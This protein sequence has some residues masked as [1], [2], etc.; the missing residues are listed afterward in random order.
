MVKFED[1]ISLSQRSFNIWKNVPAPKRAGYLREIA[2]CFKDK[3]EELAKTI[4]LDMGKT[5]SESRGEVQEAID[6]FEYA[7]GLSRN[8]SGINVPSERSNHR[9]FEQWHPLGPIGIITAFNFPLAVWAWNAAIATVCGN[10]VIWKPSE[11]TPK[12]SLMTQNLIDD[13]MPLDGIFNLLLGGKNGGIRLSKDKRI[14]LIS[15]TGSCKMGREVYKNVANRVGKCLLELGGNNAVIITKF[16]NIDLTLKSVLFSA[17]GTSGQ[18]CTSLRRLIIH[19]DILDKVIKKLIKLYKSIKIGNPLEEDTLM[20]P[21]VDQNA[22]NNMKDVLIK[23]KRSRYT[24]V[25]YGGKTNGLFADPTIVHVYNPELDFVKEETFAPILYVMSYGNL[26]DAINIQN[27]VSQGLSS[28]IYTNNINESEMFLS[29]NGSDCGI[30]NVNAGT[31]GAEIGLAFGG[32]KETGGGREAGS[33]SWKQYM[34]RQ[35]CVI[36]Y[37][38]DLPLSQGIK[39]GD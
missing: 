37:G 6:I 5:I 39:F 33:D 30:A 17:I 23:I 32:E 2:N 38:N 20:G 10:T 34:R 27:N 16:A 21:L 28:C 14:P 22:I 19:E 8:I 11:K 4:T 7:A 36:N 9:L 12:I 26:E 3:K 15:A 13:I 1:I 29:V 18:R 25:L 35:T 31:S 24:K